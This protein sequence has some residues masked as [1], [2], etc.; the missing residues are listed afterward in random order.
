MKV[1]LLGGAELDRVVATV[2]GRDARYSADWAAAG[3]IIERA[4]IEIRPGARDTGNWIAFIREPDA[5]IG[6]QWI[7]PSPLVAA[8]RAY[9][10]QKFGEEV[11]TLTPRL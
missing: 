7:G 2:D 9:V 5:A 10:A 6:R 4:R 3:P 11:P 8:M 1:E